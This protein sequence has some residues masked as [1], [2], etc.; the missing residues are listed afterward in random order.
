[1]EWMPMA[2]YFGTWTAVVIPEIWGG[3]PDQETASEFLRAETSIAAQS[4]REFLSS[5]GVR[6]D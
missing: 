1:M 2:N 6:W 3:E 4:D 5:L